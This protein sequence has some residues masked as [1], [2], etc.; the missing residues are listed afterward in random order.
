MDADVAPLEELVELARSY[1]ARLLVDEAH[2]T[3]ALGPGG[4]GAVAE[5]GLEGE[6]DV[7]VGT[8]GKALGSYGAYVCSDA[9]T[10]DYLVNAARP[11]IF[12]T[13]PAPPAVA[14]A[15]AALELIESRPHRVDRLR[16]AARA[17]RGALAD[18]GF[19]VRSSEMHI[20]PLVVGEDRAAAELSQLAVE[21]G[22]FAQAIRPPSVPAGGARLRLTVM[23][24]HTA[25][26]LRAAARAL[27]RAAEELGLD[28]EAIGDATGPAEPAAAQPPEP[29]V[30][31]REDATGELHVVEWVSEP[32]AGGGGELPETASFDVEQEW[33]A[34]DMAVGRGGPRSD[35]GA[36]RA[37]RPRARGRTARGRLTV[38]RRRVAAVSLAGAIDR[39]GRRTAGGVFVTGT[40]TGVGK[41]VLSA[42]LLA[43]VAAS[44]S[45][46]RA[47]KPVVTGLEEPAGAWPPR[48]RAARR[49]HRYGGGG[50]GSRPLR[51]RDLAAPRR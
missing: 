49:A 36:A 41:T 1:D 11:L 2:A 5:A 10:V 8:L 12:S 22:V 15:L 39:P 4:R 32:A 18:E 46:V 20:V 51:P 9:A 47:H 7:L 28:P 34:E 6:V 17:L 26:E 31:A 45:R 25:R 14:A 27:A 24:S 19:A 23:A 30:V 29:G 3:G 40:D 48:P 37:V 38:R 43:A 50:G 35:P 21:R 44:G 16:L 42:A 13:A 33:A